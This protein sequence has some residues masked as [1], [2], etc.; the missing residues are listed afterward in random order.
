M[1]IVELNLV[2]GYTVNKASLATLVS[3]GKARFYETI[4]DMRHQ[5]IEDLVS[6]HIP[7]NAYAEQWDAAATLIDRKVDPASGAVTTRMRFDAEDFEYSVRVAPRGD[8]VA[9]LVTSDVGTSQD[10]VAQ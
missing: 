7:E 5:V 6:R 9:V 2:S 4:D 8:Q 1:A 3:D 10:I